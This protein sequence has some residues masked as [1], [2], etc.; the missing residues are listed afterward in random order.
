MGLVALV[1]IVICDTVVSRAA[2]G[3][4]YNTPDEM[5]DKPVALVLGT[6]YKGAGGHLNPYFLYRIQAAVQLYKAGKVKYIIVSGDNSRKEYDESS[7]MKNLLVKLGVP[8]EVIYTDYAG[9]RT[10]DSVVRCKEI[11]GQKNIVVVSQEFHNERAIY[12]ARAKGI[13]AVGLN[14]KNVNAR[15]GLPVM[16]REKLARVKAVLDIMFNKKPHF[17]GPSIELGSEQV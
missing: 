6:S 12:L 16:L 3:R 13:N 1:T 11:F 5:Q 9:F 14:A 15:T 10:L 2:N 17:L 7:D 4:L 8:E